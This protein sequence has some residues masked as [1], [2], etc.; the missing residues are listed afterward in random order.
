[1]FKSALQLVRTVKK[2]LAAGLYITRLLMT[3]K[4]TIFSS[5]IIMSADNGIQHRSYAA[6][7][8][9]E[10][11]ACGREG[12]HTLGACSNVQDMSPCGTMGHG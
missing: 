2:G 11:V 5:G 4:I 3:S 8:E 7:V 10:C 6:T 9:K 12:N 1:M